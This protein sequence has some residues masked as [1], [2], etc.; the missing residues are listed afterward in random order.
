V[1]G[2]IFH[3]WNTRI[4]PAAFIST[5]TECADMVSATVPVN[6]A[7][8]YDQIRTDRLVLLGVGMEMHATAMLY[9]RNE[10]GSA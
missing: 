9:S 6:L 5:L 10:V 8:C 7:M 1:S 4:R 3:E 2:R